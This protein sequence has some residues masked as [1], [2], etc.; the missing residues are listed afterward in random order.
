MWSHLSFV[1]QD[2]WNGFNRRILTVG[3]YPV[4]IVEPK[5]VMPGIPII[6][7]VGDDDATVPVAEN[8]DIVERRYK[9]MG[10]NICVIHRPGVG[11]HPH[12]LDDQAPVVDFILRHI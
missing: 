5:D 8:S 2:K 11:H 7:V 10:G 6:H 9:E 4:W 12:G 3:G 1:Q